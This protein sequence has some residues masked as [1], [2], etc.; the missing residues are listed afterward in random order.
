MSKKPELLQ[1]HYH[2]WH[3]RRERFME[4]LCVQSQQL[5]LIESALLQEDQSEIITKVGELDFELL[6]YTC[7]SLESGIVEAARLDC[8]H[9]IADSILDVSV[10]RVSGTSWENWLTAASCWPQLAQEQWKYARSKASD[11][12]VERL[13]SAGVSMNATSAKEIGREVSSLELRDLMPPETY[14]RIFT[15]DTTDEEGS[16]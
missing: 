5:R 13:E 10:A 2:D 7:Y 8:A 4:S 11:V 3:L 12:V 9:L 14:N 15:A 6:R 1:H 16:E